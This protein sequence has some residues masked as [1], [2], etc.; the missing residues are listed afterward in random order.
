MAQQP[1]Q[2]EY[3]RVEPE[4]IPPDHSRAWP[5]GWRSHPDF[6]QVRGTHRI[7]VTRLGPFGIAIMLLAFAVLTA[8]I[9]LALIGAVLLWLPVVAL[10]VG[11]LVAARL[12]RRRIF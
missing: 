3:P 5:P 4:I 10:I 1:E 2:P 9:L 12:F 11:A 6:Y 8:A 7:Q